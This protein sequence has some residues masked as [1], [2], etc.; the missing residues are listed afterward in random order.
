MPSIRIYRASAGSGKTFTLAVEYI[1]LLAINPMAYQNILAVTFTNKATA[2]MKQRILGTLYG[3]AHGLDEAEPYVEKI[4]KNLQAMRP[5]SCWQEEPW[6]T[7]LA[8]ANRDRLRT[9]AQE[10]LANIIHD[11]SRFRIETIDSFFQS[12]V[13]ELAGELELSAKLKVELDD[14][15]VLSEA[16]D[17]IIEELK[18]GSSEFR[19]IIAFIEEKIRENH[20][21][22]VEDTVKTFGQNIFKEKY[23]IHGEDVRQ[24]ITDS[25]ALYRYRE[26]L[27]KLIEEKRQ[28]VI[29]QAETLKTAYDNLGMTEKDSSQK[30]VTFIQKVCD[31]NVT[32]PSGQK[33]GTFSETIEAYTT[34]ATLWLKKTS[35]RKDDFLPRIESQLM[36][37]L[38]ETFR[39]NDEYVRHLNS[40]SAVSQHL[41]SLMLLNEISRTVKSQSEEAGRF[42]L[43]ETAHFLRDVMHGE[44]IPFIY[45][46]TGA[47]INHIM[48]DE[49]Q[50]T[51][52][53]Q[54]GNF[55]PLIQNSLS[56]GGS[57][58]IVGDVKQSIYRF[59]NSD[60][61]ILNNLEHDTDL[62]GQTEQIPASFNY[63][64]SRRIVEFCGAFFRKTVE[65]LQQEC[66][67]LVTAY[68]DVVQKP[69]KQK[70]EG[71][72]RVENIDYHSIDPKAPTDEWNYDLSPDYTEATLQ[73]IHHS[74][75][76]LLSNGVKPSDITILTRTNKEVPLISAYFDDHHE[77]LGVSVVSDDAFRLDASPAVNI[78]ICALRLIADPD[79]PLH[80]AALTHQLSAVNS[81]HSSSGSTESASSTSEL[82]PQLL[83]PRSLRFLSLSQ[84]VE[85]IC[86]TFAL[87]QISGQDAYLLYF[88]D[89]V[90]QFSQD[91][92]ATT[93]AFLEAWDE[94]LCAK[95]I[96][97][98]TS[99]G[100][101][102]MTMHK[103]KGLEFH[104]VIIPFCSW[105]LLPKGTEVI[106]CTPH[107]A[108]Y[109][110]MPLL[111]V[112]VSHA[113]DESIFAEDRREEELRT[114]VDNINILYVAFTRAK[115]N[116]IILT[117]RSQSQPKAL[118]LNNCQSLLTLALPT[119]ELSMTNQEDD[120][121]TIH[122]LGQVKPSDKSESSAIS[123]NSKHSENSENP[124]QSDSPKNLLS[125]TPTPQPARFVSHPSPAAFR[126]SFDSE[127]FIT[128]E[129]LNPRVQRHARRIHLISLGNLYHSIFERIHTIDDV[130]HA[131]QHLASKGC[132]SSLLDA[133]EAQ[134]SITQLIQEITPEHP[135]WFSPKWQVLNERAIL[136]LDDEEQLANKRPDRVVVCGS[137][138]IIIDY[139]TAQGVVQSAAD[140]TL[141][142]PDENKNQIAS[143]CQLL[144]QMGYT[145]VKAFL[146]YILDHTVVEVQ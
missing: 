5:M 97:G 78:I 92:M 34:D 63:R 2:E 68:G 46:K 146:W 127:M 109:D 140:G 31:Y 10:A 50:D 74:V 39:L 93:D 20:S 135:E 114:L 51:S 58:L 47:V 105:N 131:V 36:P 118:K 64:S 117:G 100:I 54:W 119:D 66:P 60:W 29:L 3:I 19:T 70:A 18:E 107:E 30:I 21:W 72:V 83:S 138:A 35:K 113:K 125:T 53:L 133:T 82:N 77:E 32:K 89:I 79:S 76:S 37:M 137:Q 128:A 80:L 139:K 124:K 16:I 4:M 111:P 75:A 85:T 1:T 108:P 6:R 44:D 101:R 25:K 45:E 43:S 42:L 110:L 65:Q 62:E 27:N 9:R 90:A 123:E 120:L 121:I 104:S 84:Q 130:P 73:R 134:E 22:Q 26:L 126:Q 144:T 59:R 41:Y 55:K 8:L 103:S 7:E 15:K 102:I 38:A 11:Y 112:S 67:A 143:Y 52:T 33:R 106:W 94:E 69:F 24:K 57:C 141:V 87:H 23:L 122:T 115:H 145:D 129:S 71:Y 96:P 12:I 17:Q 142:P 56:S 132:F 81:S 13:R 98:G 91:K 48:I 116:L 136:F 88:A 14:S 99:D 61:Q 95:T 40:V 28:A 86:Q 49:F